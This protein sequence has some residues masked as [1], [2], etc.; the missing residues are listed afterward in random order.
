VR[1]WREELSKEGGY[2]KGNG[3]Q[4]TKKVNSSHGVLF[5]FFSGT[6]AGKIEFS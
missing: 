6:Y 4:H 2:E 3:V 5:L 1:E